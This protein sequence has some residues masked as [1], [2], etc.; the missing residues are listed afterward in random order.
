MYRNITR[1]KQ[2]K[3]KQSSS[4]DRSPNVTYSKSEGLSIVFETSSHV[5]P[6]IT[7]GRTKQSSVNTPVAQGDILHM[8]EQAAQSGL[9]KEMLECFN[10]LIHTENKVNQES[11]DQGLLLSCRYGREFLVKILIFHGAN[12]ETRDEDGNTPLLICAEKGFTDIALLLA[13]K[14]ADI[15]SYNKDGDTALLLSIKTSGSSQLGTRLLE[16]CIINVLHTNT[17]GYTFLMRA[18]EVLDFSLL[19]T[20]I[21]RKH[22]TLK[23]TIE[24]M[25]NLGI[26]N[27]DINII[28]FFINYLNDRKARVDE[29]DVIIVRTLL[30]AMFPFCKKNIRSN[31]AHL[32]SAL[33]VAVKLDLLIKLNAKLNDWRL[34]DVAIKKGQIDCAKLLLKSGADVDVKRTISNAVTGQ[35]PKS[36]LVAVELF[37]EQSQELLKD[38]GVKF[39]LQAVN[40]GDRETINSLVKKGVDVNECFDGKTALIAARDANILK[41]LINLGDDVN[42]V[43]EIGRK[44]CTVLSY[45]LKYYIEYTKYLE[46]SLQDMINVI[47]RYLRNLN[48]TDENGDTYLMLALLIPELF[49]TACLLLQK[50]A[51]VNLQND[52]GMTALHLAVLQ[53]SKQNIHILL[54]YNANVNIK[55]NKGQ[56]ALHLAVKMKTHQNVST[57]L[58]NKAN[59]DIQSNY[60][61]TALHIAVMRQSMPCVMILLD[62]KAN[63]NLKTGDGGTP[64]MIAVAKKN[65]YITELLI[66]H[67]ASVNAEDSN[68]ET[69]LFKLTNVCYSN[70]TVE[71]MLRVVKML[72]AAGAYLEHQNNEGRTAL[73]QAAEKKK[74]TVLQVLCEAGSNVNAINTNKDETALS[75]CF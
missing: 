58:K 57:L 45:I 53:N 52:D 32:D 49:S 4:K 40:D 75:K 23:L 27:D 11:L 48:T 34:F 19:E 63:T 25:S 61:Q 46:R 39:L 71:H 21:G 59:V 15:N 13:D 65:I 30:D 67:G 26:R 24:N 37:E 20:F 17:A 6:E 9:P 43:I 36:F 22:K 68:G 12:I 56:T 38:Y 16:Q 14:G 55:C 54:Q 42:K 7:R 66:K 62:Y 29:T 47:L 35:R 69:P 8:I 2:M 31:H 60:G 41:L 50:G 70:A 73:M 3:Q 28:T 51:N 64:L 74:I 18:F 44:K 1:N 10:Q 33:P 72:Q 5:N